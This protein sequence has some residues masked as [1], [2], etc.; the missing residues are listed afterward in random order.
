MFRRDETPGVDA[1]S[2]RARVAAL[3]RD[4]VGTGTRWN[5]DDQSLDSIGGEIEAEPAADFGVA[6]HAGAHESGDGWVPDPRVGD[7]VARQARSSA[8][9]RPFREYALGR[10]PAKRRSA[11]PTE[12]AWRDAEVEQYVEPAASGA[13]QRTTAPDWATRV[14]SSGPWGELAEKWVPESLRGARVDPGRRGAVLVSVVA[15]IAAIVAAVGVWWAKPV[16]IPLASSSIAGEA[17]DAGLS[18]LVG[19]GAAAES[20]GNEIIPADPQT[21][22]AERV[23]GGS[24]H[25][26]PGTTRAAATDPGEPILVSVTGKVRNPG[27]VT[28][29][30]DARVADAIAAAGGAVDDAQ[31]TGLNLAAHLT[32]GASVV[33]GGPGGG[34]VVGEISAVG[35]E[36]A[37]NCGVS[38]AA[39]LINV[40]TADSATLQTLAGV[41]PVTAEAIVTYRT[42]HG[43]FTELAQLQ[44]VSGIGPATLARLKPHV[45][46]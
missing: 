3:S 27:V 8:R 12:A 45:T 38:G 11:E 29:P 10:A 32:D 7:A 20:S 2:A 31:L 9:R 1:A 18:T 14:T 28:V 41:G 19:T 4:A 35:A 43:P 15:A 6:T 23:E 42:D 17:S 40:N 16:P 39:G 21:S 5:A 34:S 46:L 36:R 22:G 37:P 26:D 33:V 24:G 44:E 25:N 13:D 30:A